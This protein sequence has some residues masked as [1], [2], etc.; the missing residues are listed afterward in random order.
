MR[1]SA[2]VSIALSQFV[3]GGALADCPYTVLE[4]RAAPEVSVDEDGTHVLRW[5]GQSLVYGPISVWDLDV[6]VKLEEQVFTATYSVANGSRWARQKTRVY[7]FFESPLLDSSSGEAFVSAGLLGGAGSPGELGALSSNCRLYDRTNY[8]SRSFGDF[9]SRHTLPPGLTD[10]ADVRG[11]L[12]I[13]G[14]AEALDEVAQLLASS[15]PKLKVL[16]SAKEARDRR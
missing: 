12:R 8:P 5:T 2:F 9:T 4:T 1:A 15:A 14:G 11:A 16:I 7:L 6:Q 10:N 13:R 3:A